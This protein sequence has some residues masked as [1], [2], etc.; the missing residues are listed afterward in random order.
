MSLILFKLLPFLVQSIHVITSIHP[1]LVYID[2]IHFYI[3]FISKKCFSSL[4]YNTSEENYILLL[5]SS[6]LLPF[7]DKEGLEENFGMKIKFLPSQSAS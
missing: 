3:P 1:S 6:E 4:L 5:I 2:F 7:P